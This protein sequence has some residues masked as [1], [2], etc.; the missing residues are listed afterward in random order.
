MTA[1]TWRRSG[2]ASGFRLAL[3]DGARRLRLASRQA[4]PV[5]SGLA[6]DDRRRLG[7]AV[8]A[9]RLDEVPVPLDDHRLLAGW[10]GPGARVPVDR[11][12]AVLD[13]NRRRRG[14]GLRLAAIPLPYV[15]PAA[16]PQ[17]RHRRAAG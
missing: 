11:R 2:R 5:E 6:T 8:A 12:A 9:L 7:V 15:V 3:P 4:R 13:V 10:H 16:V 17:G 1:R 14:G